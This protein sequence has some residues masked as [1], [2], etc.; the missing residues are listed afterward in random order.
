M[1]IF[2]IEVNFRGEFILFQYHSVQGL[3]VHPAEM[4]KKIH[5]L[6]PDQGKYCGRGVLLVHMERRSESKTNPDNARSEHGRSQDRSNR[7]GEV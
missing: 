7:R 1:D 4:I 3:T 2:T 5:P 6:D